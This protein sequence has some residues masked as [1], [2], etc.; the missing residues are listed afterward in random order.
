VSATWYLTAV[1]VPLNVGNGS[2]VTVP[3]AF[4]VYVPSFAIVN[5]VCVQLFG[6]CALGATPHNFTV[7][8]TN[9]ALTA[10]ATSLVSG[11]IVWFASQL[12]VLVSGLATGG[13]G[14][15][16]VNVLVAV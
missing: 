6:V 11:E 4:T 2:N 15:T 3:F 13:C 12:P 14:M 1:A 10:P 9:G 16:G 8:A 5:E 7:E